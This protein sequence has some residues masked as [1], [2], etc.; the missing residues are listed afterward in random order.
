MALKAAAYSVTG[1]VGLLSDALE[2]VVNLVAALLAVAMLRISLRPPDQ[3]HAFG[4]EKFEF[5]SS[6]VEGGLILVAA[7]SIAYTALPRLWHP[8]VLEEIGLGM[9]LATIAS[10][11]NGLVALVLLRAGRKYRSAALE[12]DGQHLMTDV[13]S[14]GA[15]LVGLLLMRLTGQ[16]ILDPILALLVAGYIAFVAVGL[17]NKASQGL[18]DTSMEST[19]VTLIEKIL[20][21]YSQQGVTYHALR[22]RR[23]GRSNFAQM[24]VL[25]PGDWT[26]RQGHELLE[27]IEKAISAAI[28]GTRVV[29]HLEPVEEPASFDDIDLD[30]GAT[31]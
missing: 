4:H 11:I 21:P 27:E 8:R 29:T 9:A 2:S 5:F 13:W 30:R 6:G 28:P 31:A 17:L 10:V 14:S 19:H 7:G 23:A 3:D 24:H 22:T 25:V 20:E 18:S 26:V 15:V 1:S 16:A 12:A